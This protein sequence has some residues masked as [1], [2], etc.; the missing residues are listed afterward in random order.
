M[1][2]W[3]IDLLVGLLLWLLLGAALV[4]TIKRRLED[5]AGLRS[6]PARL[7]ASL[8]ALLALA[9][10]FVVL[11][12]SIG[13]FGFV[14]GRLVP[15]FLIVAALAAERSA[16]SR[17][18]RAGWD[19]GVAVGAVAIVAIAWVASWRFQPEAAGWQ[20]TVAAIHDRTLL[21]NLPLDPNSDVFTA[22]PFVHYDKLAVA[23]KP[24]VVSDVWFHQGTAIYPT[25]LNPASR[26]PAEYSESNLQR[27]DWSS[28]RLED[29]DYVLVRTKPGA[30]GP[31]AP[32]T[33]TLVSHDG[34]WWLY[35]TGRGAEV[36]STQ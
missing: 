4:A 25:P 24:V 17:W 33:L 35:T 8:G 30:P 29:W 27:I 16:M 26:L 15:I 18:V 21:L 22:H 13:W 2:R 34:G 14:D 3:G 11:P 1:T 36:S 7:R 32:E 12:R 9:V 6:L 19:S 23:E 20:D 28:Y 5:G 31:Q 10:A